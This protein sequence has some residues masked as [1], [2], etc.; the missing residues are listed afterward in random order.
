[1]ESQNKQLNL[2]VDENAEP[3]RHLIEQEEFLL[4][5]MLS[6]KLTDLEQKCYKNMN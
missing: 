1:M 4:L 5:K 6:I 2:V 3:A